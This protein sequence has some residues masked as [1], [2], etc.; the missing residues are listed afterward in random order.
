MLGSGGMARSHLEA[1][2]CVRPIGRLQVYSPTPANRERFAAEVRE[3]H[4]IEVRVCASPEEIYRGAHIVAALTD[5]TV[6][7]L[8]GTKL[9]PGAHIVNIGGGGVPDAASLA[10]ID[11]CLRFGRRACSRSGP[12][13]GALRRRIP[14]L[15]GP[16]GTHPRPG[17]EGRPRAGHAG[18]DRF[19]AR[20]RQRRATGPAKRNRDHVVRTRE[21]AGRAVLWPRGARVRC[22]GARS[23]GW[24]GAADAVAASGYKGPGTRQ[25]H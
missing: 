14:G 16:A 8:D 24:A 22:E 20:C 12:R 11:R 18:E 6:P 2:L 5:S 3:K 21:P 15:V 25:R 17:E 9:E 23:R 10:R 1:F 19:P 4:G 7:V 13:R